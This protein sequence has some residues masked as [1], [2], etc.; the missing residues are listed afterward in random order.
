MRSCWPL[1]CVCGGCMCIFCLGG[2]IKRQHAASQEVLMP[3]ISCSNVIHIPSVIQPARLM[4]ESNGDFI[5]N[6][7]SSS[8]S[9][10]LP[11]LL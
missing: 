1:R 3:R 2:A 4:Y 7:P 10:V 8:S 11:P 9:S 5:S 6:T